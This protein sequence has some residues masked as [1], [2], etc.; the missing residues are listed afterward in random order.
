MVASGNKISLV[1]EIEMRRFDF[2][3]GHE[4]DEQTYLYKDYSPDGSYVLATDAIELTSGAAE[5][6]DALLEYIDALPKDLVLPGMPGVDRD[7]VETVLQ[8]LKSASKGD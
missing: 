3:V 6:I 2:A 4:S 1:N 8:Q 7:W 5:V